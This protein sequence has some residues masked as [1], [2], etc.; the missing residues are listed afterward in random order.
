VLPVREPSRSNP[1]RA[2]SGKRRRKRRLSLVPGLVLD[3]VLLARNAP[4]DLGPALRPARRQGLVQ[5]VPAALPAARDAAS[6]KSRRLVRIAQL[7]QARVRKV[8]APGVRQLPVE[9]SRVAEPHPSARPR[10][11]VEANREA[12]PHPRDAVR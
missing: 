7:W 12:G 2:V 5:L 4:A 10:P 8:I 11:N 3:L 6:W 1:D 9:A